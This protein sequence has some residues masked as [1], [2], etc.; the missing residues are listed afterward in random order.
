MVL[1]VLVHDMTYKDFINN[2]IIQRGYD[3]IHGTY[4]EYHHIVPKCIGGTDDKTNLISLTPK[5]HFIAHKLLL[6]ENPDNVQLMGALIMVAFMRSKNQERYIPTEEEYQYLKKVNSEFVS[7]SQKGLCWCYHI[8]THER[9]RF[10]INNIP[11]NF[12]LGLPS[13]YEW[14]TKGK[15]LSDGQKK[16]LS[17]SKKDKYTGKKWYNNGIIE[18]LVYNCPENF[19]EGRLPFSDRTKENI[20]KSNLGKTHSDFTKEKLSNSKNGKHVYN[21]GKITIRAYECPIGFEPGF[22]KNDKLSN[23]KFYTNGEKTIKI[24]NGDDVPDGFYLGMAK[25]DKL[26]NRHWYTNGIENRWSIEC[27]EGFHSGKT[28]TCTRLRDEAGK[29][30]SRH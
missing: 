14:P 23:C 3:G 19:I 26:Q 29:F 11:P 17:Q 4:H 27:P 15:S 25:N 7:K 20:S 24:Y 2:I 10:K 18:V 28:E 13:E 30:K 9:K 8:I 12:V 5:E 16:K 1:E 6:K 22:L 21:N